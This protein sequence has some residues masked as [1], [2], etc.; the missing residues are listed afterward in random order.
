MG[1]RN[2]CAA[3]LA[4]VGR[5]LGYRFSFPM[6]AAMKGS[7]ATEEGQVTEEMTAIGIAPM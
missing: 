6:T 1:I 7:S 3:N 4:L 2:E 5:S